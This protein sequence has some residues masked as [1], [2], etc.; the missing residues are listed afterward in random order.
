MSE[1]FIK[2]CVCGK[3]LAQCRC[4]NIGGRKKVE[5]VSP[6]KCEKPMSEQKYPRLGSTGTLWFVQFKKDGSEWYMPDERTAR[7]CAHAAE[8]FALLRD[9]DNEVHMGPENCDII[10]RMD[11]LLL[12]VTHTPTLTDD[13]DWNAQ[14]HASVQDEQGEGE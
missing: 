14:N 11:A 1:H 13:G 10:E 4:P 8:A 9:I 6:C 2:T 7:R 3:V 5:T 12:K